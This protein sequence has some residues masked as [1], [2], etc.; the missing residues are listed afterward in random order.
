MLV[1]LQ[2]SAV[3]ILSVSLI[4]PLKLFLSIQWGSQ[5]SV[6]PMAFSVTCSLLDSVPLIYVHEMRKD[7]CTVSLPRG[8]DRAVVGWVFDCW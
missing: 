5:W 1:L 6:S 2:A 7:T 4:F 3:L 8:F